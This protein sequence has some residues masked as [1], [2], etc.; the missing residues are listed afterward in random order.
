MGTS[1]I[2]RSVEFL[3]PGPLAWVHYVRRFWRF[4]R[5]HR[6]VTFNEHIT[7]RLIFDRDPL[8][9]TVCDKIATKGLVAER[10]GPR[11]V[12][13]LLGAW[14]RIADIPW[15]ELP[16]SF[17]V[18]PSFTSGPFELVG[19]DTDREALA[20]DMQAWLPRRPPHRHYREWGYKGVPRKVMAEPLVTGPRADDVAHECDVHVFNGRALLLRVLT[21][22]KLTSSRRDTWFDRDGRPLKIRV[23]KI[24]S[25]P[26]DLPPGLRNEL[27]EVAERVARGFR[28]MRVD[29]YLT[30]EGVKV[31]ELTA[32]PWAGE[33]TWAVPELD[34]MMGRLFEP[35]A[36]TS[37][38]EDY[39]P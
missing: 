39:E 13:P 35:G 2:S 31:G 23:E 37:H 30:P 1:I 21:G 17:A 26:Y 34:E 33:A 7:H 27:I 3:P 24:R 28:F 32:Y 15:S 10:A 11:H 29:T 19:P 4:P 20:R 36:D 38:F 6:P 5:L 25:Q 12:V 14:S 22:R 16:E 9:K 8:L 18:K